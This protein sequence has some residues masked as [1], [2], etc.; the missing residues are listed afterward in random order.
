MSCRC[1]PANGLPFGR[2]V[3]DN[4]QLLLIRIQSRQS[5]DRLLTLRLPSYSHFCFP[6]KRA[7]AH[8]EKPALARV[9]RVVNSCDRRQRA[10][11]FVCILSKI[12]GRRCH[13]GL[14]R[15]QSSRRFKGY[16]I[17]P[18]WRQ[19][20][21][22]GNFFLREMKFEAGATEDRTLVG[23]FVIS[24]NRS[25]SDFIRFRQ[26]NVCACWP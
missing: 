21:D 25:P 20:V 9:E 15:V 3:V 2:V 14:R 12:V 26:S 6:C 17:W 4:R 24:S 18:N 7:S 5:I 11:V 16:F 19:I 13:S 1:A 23:R 8:N 22:D 10:R